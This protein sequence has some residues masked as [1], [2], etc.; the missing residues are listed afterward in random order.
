MLHSNEAFSSLQI[1]D[2]KGFLRFRIS[3]EELEAFFIGIRQS[4]PRMGTKWSSGKT[5]SEM[6]TSERR[7]QAA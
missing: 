4:S 1:E 5:A 2:Y 7:R 6:E 3:E